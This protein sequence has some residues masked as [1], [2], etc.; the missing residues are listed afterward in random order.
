M[1]DNLNAEGETVPDYSHQ[2]FVDGNLAP[3]HKED[4][5]KTVHDVPKGVSDKTHDKYL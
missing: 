3:D 1:R 5:L 2:N 4:L